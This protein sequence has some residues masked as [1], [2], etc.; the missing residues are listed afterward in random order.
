MITSSLF[1]SPESTARAKP[2][3]ALSF[4]GGLAVLGVLFSSI[5]EFGMTSARLNEIIREP[6]G[7]SYWLL[8]ITNALFRTNAVALLTVLFGAGILLFLNG[9]QPTTGPAIPELY[10]RRQL[11]LVLFGLF[12]ALV[13]LAPGDLLFFYAIIGVFLFPF[14]RLPARALFICA[15]VSG[16]LFAGKYYWNFAEN[17]QKYEAY[18]KV[19]ALEKKNKKV[20]LN[21]EQKED[22][23]AWEGLARQGTFDKKGEETAIRAMRSDYGTVWSHLLPRIQQAESAD[24]YQLRLWNFASLL[25]LGMA[26]FKSGFLLNQLT[27]RQYAVLAV[28]GLALGQALA[29][30]TLPV[31][32]RSVLDFT[33]YTTTLLLPWHLIVQPLEQAAMAIGYA[34]LG[35]LI[36]RSSLF[37]S[38]VKALDAVGQMALTNYLLQSVLCTLFFNGYGFSYFGDLL[39]YQLFFVV[40]EIWLLQT[41]LSLVWLRYFYFGPAEWLWYSLIHQRRL[42]MQIPSEEP[43]QMGSSIAVLS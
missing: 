19:V 9:P 8:T 37:K 27:T 30:L 38:L 33:K 20:K 10:I 42:P 40:A 34:S 21:D 18:Q 3:S 16:L 41:L 2:V 28:A 11:W 29:W 13:L 43:A 31:A 14:G 39:Y 23:S 24:F 6:H 4:L 32:E 7:A 15:L 5:Q 17:K 35:L 12:N 25:L 26:L 36:Y 1:S 22:K